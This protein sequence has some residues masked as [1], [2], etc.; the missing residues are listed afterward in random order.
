MIKSIK[1]VFLTVGGEFIFFIG[2]IVD[3]FMKVGGEIILVTGMVV[4]K[5]CFAFLFSSDVL[6]SQ[7]AV[8]DLK[9]SLF[10]FDG[11]SAG[12]GVV[13]IVLKCKKI[14]RTVSDVKCMQGVVG[15]V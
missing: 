12:G 9:W 7:G 14:R 1:K 2:E 15:Y 6:K 3:L 10:Q 4:V 5:V 8:I 13:I 11:E